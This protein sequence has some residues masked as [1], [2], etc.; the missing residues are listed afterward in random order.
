VNISVSGLS[1]SKVSHF[2]SDHIKKPIFSRL[3]NTPVVHDPLGPDV[4]S[5]VALVEKHR[6][7]IPCDI[8]GEHV[9]DLGSAARVGQTQG[10]W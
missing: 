4:D 3:L 1:S 5:E 9:G 2:R 10:W 6:S 7:C 8:A